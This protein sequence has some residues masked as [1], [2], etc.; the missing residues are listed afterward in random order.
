MTAVKGKGNGICRAPHWSTDF[1]RLYNLFD[2]E[3]IRRNY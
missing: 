3:Q 2:Q 1:T